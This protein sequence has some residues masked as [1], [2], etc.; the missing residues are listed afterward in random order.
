MITLISHFYNEEFLL[1]H[2]I[3]HHTKLFD[4]GI[5]IDYDSTDR[6]VEIIKDMAP[7]WEV[8][9]S[10]DK[11][12]RAGPNDRQIESIEKSIN[13]WKA[14]FTITEFLFCDSLK[15]YICN[16]ENDNPKSV[17]F[18]TRGVIMV[19]QFSERGVYDPSL[20]L[21]EQKHHG[22]F[23]EDLLNINV[24]KKFENSK[25]FKENYEFQYIKGFKKNYRKKDGRTRLIHK[26]STGDY[27]DGR[28]STK[29]KNVEF[30]DLVLCCFAW[31]PFD[32]IIDRKLQIIHKCDAGERNFAKRNPMTRFTYEKENLEDRYA[33]HVKFSS[34]L[35]EDERYK[36]K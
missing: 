24:D 25:S 14:A 36:K 23:E 34:N 35:L 1:P 21:L 4:H 7:T 13:G 33:A 17:G 31:C 28:H 8:V 11:V 15:N 30:S 29:L 19:D 12:F 18:N 16:F 20:P 26:V 3:D 6:S 10:S 9:M 27:N 5:L 32:Y 2:W 22:Y